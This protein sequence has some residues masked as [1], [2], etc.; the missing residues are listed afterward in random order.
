MSG[1]EM[2]GLSSSRPRLSVREDTSSPSPVILAAGF[3][4]TVSVNMVNYVA[5]WIGYDAEECILKALEDGEIEIFETS[6]DGSRGYDIYRLTAKGRREADRH[7]REV[8]QRGRETARREYEEWL[9]GNAWPEVAVAG[10]PRGDGPPADTAA[11]S[12]SSPQAAAA[13]GG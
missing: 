7:L 2:S 1:T 11:S 13:A 6:P 8:F 5:R 10:S 9:K 12:S 4:K 3:E